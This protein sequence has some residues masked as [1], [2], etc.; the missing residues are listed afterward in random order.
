MNSGWAVPVP[1]QQNELFSSWL[2][3]AALAQGCDPLVLTGEVWPRWR[4]WVRDLDRGVSEER[5]FAL[6]K[7]SGIPTKVFEAASLRPMV[8]GITTESLDNLAVWPWVLALGYKNRKR[9]GGLQ[10]CPACLAIDQRPYYRLQWRLAWHV[11]CSVHNTQLHDRCWNCSASVQPHRLQAEDKHLALCS[12]CRNDLREARFVVDSGSSFAFQQTAD[13]VIRKGYG[14]YGRQKVSSKEWF[15]LS[16]YFLLILR[17]VALGQAE[18][19]ESVVKALGVTPS[20]IAA[21][22]TGLAFELLPVE[23]R[24]PLLMGVWELLDAGP[25]RFREAAMQA[26]LTRATFSGIY[27]PVPQ[28]IAALVEAL[29]DGSTL[30]VNAIQANGEPRPRSREAVMRMFARLQ[31]KMHRMT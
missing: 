5:L 27:Q 9:L 1:L 11:S 14:Y 28:S 24:A 16:R 23:E 19:L 20:A 21:P 29:P 17:R 22:A 10:Y 4:A 18:G 7:V 6:A 30:R 15:Q 25:G 31:R 3:R 13:E 26:S 2:A 8:G 12:S